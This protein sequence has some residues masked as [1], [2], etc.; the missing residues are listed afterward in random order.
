MSAVVWRLSGAG[1]GPPVVEEELPVAPPP[2]PRQLGEAELRQV[3]RR[4]ERRLAELRIFLREM[5][6]RLI[7]NRQSVPGRRGWAADS[8]GQTR[9]GT[10]SAG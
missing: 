1:C 5:C 2:P 6:G 8:A 7:R 4:E 3:Q 9:L 10:D